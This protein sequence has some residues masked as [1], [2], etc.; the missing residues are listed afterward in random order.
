MASSDEVLKA[1]DHLELIVVEGPVAEGHK[2][3]PPAR[4]T[5]TT[6]TIGRTK[7]S[8]IYIKDSAV[9]EKHGLLRWID[10]GW[11]LSDCGSSNGT[12]VNGERLI[13]SGDCGTDQESGKRLKDGDIIQFGTDTK[14]RAEISPHASENVT[15]EQFLEAECHRLIQRVQ[16]RYEQH[17]N[18]LQE[19]WETE[20]Q[21]QLH[22]LLVS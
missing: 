2:L 9:S 15:V 11:V 10:N 14:V 4:F 16:G 6:L 5:S 12:L 19:E 20:H 18:Q 22:D 17:A 7:A 13:D 1:P 8:R 21:K 3:L